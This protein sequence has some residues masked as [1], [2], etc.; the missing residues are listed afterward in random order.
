VPEAGEH[1][2]AVL[3]AVLGAGADELRQARDGGAFGK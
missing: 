2:D 1:T 3:Q